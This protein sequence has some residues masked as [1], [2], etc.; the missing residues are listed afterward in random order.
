MSMDVQA[1]Q[2]S[3]VAWQDTSETQASTEAQSTSTQSAEAPE[4]SGAATPAAA[5]GDS[6][7]EAAAPDRLG[8]S[9]TTMQGASANG[10][11]NGGDSAARPDLVDSVGRA[12]AEVG[13][14]FKGAL[15]SGDTGNAVG[16]IDA[17]DSGVDEQVRRA[18][19]RVG[20]AAAEAGKAIGDGVEKAGKAVE[21]GV[22][23]AGKAIQKGVEDAGKAVEEGVRE[24]G[25]AIEKGI[26][27]TGKALEEG[28]K[29]AGKAIE[30]GAEDAGKAV[31][32]ALDKSGV[33]EGSKIDKLGRGDKCTKT[34]EPEY[35]IGPVKLGGKLTVETQ[36]TNDDKYVVSVDTE[37]SGAIGGGGSVEAE[38]GGKLGA[39][40]E[41]TFNSAAEAK[42]A[43]GIITAQMAKSSQHVL[44]AAETE[45]QKEK[46]DREWLDKH[47][48]ATETRWAAGGKVE[49][50]SAS[51]GA[52]GEVSGEY[53]RTER[54]EYKNGEPT[55]VTFKTK[56]K[57]E[58]KAGMGGGKADVK[59]VEVD[60]DSR[61]GVQGSATVEVEKKVN[62]QKGM[63]IEQARAAAEKM[64]T[65]KVTVTTDTKRFEGGDEKGTETKYEFETK[66]K[67]VDAAEIARRVATG[68]PD[69]FYKGLPKGTEVEVTET[70]YK[71]YGARFKG[72]VGGLDVKIGTGFSSQRQD[73]DTEHERKSKT[74]VGRNPGRQAP[75]PAPAFWRQVS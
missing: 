56:A 20:E 11:S 66:G 14:R 17:G 74:T 48:T 40:T 46:E 27:E 53:E 75:A 61:E 44:R 26:E 67:S 8:I 54:I 38:G 7:E 9:S 73:Y 6:Y 5:T 23:E 10:N 43:E 33:L 45:T 50:S 69:E 72:S 1:A 4:Q 19:E 41:Y 51:G 60:V 30:K 16:G 71:T 57:A 22:R 21:E 68:G 13:T 64:E 18:A 3:S 37:G 31:E 2:S 25:K 24:A 52:R 35:G 62:W 39:K 70:D 47:R 29:E 63:T 36:R 59:G 32:E 12:C 28:A 49:G 55:S 42:R 15:S 58:G 34:I 65:S